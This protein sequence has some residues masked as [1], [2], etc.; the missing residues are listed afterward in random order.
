MRHIRRP[1]GIGQRIGTP[2]EV[3]ASPIVQG[4][5]LGSLAEVPA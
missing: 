1:V 5:Y 2:A 3:I 4:A